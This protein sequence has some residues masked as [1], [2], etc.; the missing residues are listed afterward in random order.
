MVLDTKWKLPKRGSPSDADLKQMFVYN[1]MY[2]VPMSL[3]VYPSGRGMH[4]GGGQFSD[5]QHRC[6]V[7]FV[8]LFTN[9]VYDSVKARAGV[10]QLLAA[11]VAEES[12]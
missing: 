2:S 5:R 7:R 1:E 6:G 3:L 9:G 4:D 8:D 12:A 10:A 11:V